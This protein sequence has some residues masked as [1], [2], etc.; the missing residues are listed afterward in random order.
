MDEQLTYAEAV[1][2]LRKAYEREK[3]QLKKHIAKLQI[4]VHQQE[5]H[6]KQIKEL[7][8]AKLV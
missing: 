3:I 8:N 1:E 4:T 7:Y 2:Q 6:I 5:I